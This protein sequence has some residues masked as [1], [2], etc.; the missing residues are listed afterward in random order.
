MITAIDVNTFG[1]TEVAE[2]LP[3]FIIREKSE[4]LVLALQCMISGDTPLRIQ[5]NQQDKLIKRISP[6]ALNVNNLLKVL[7]VIYYKDAEGVEHG[8]TNIKEYL[9]VVW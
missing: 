1:T 8:I 7:S 9:E 3:A 4:P 6:S 2:E 5:W